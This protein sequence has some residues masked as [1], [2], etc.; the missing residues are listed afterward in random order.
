MSKE[1]IMFDINDVNINFLKVIANRYRTKLHDITPVHGRIIMS[2]YDSKND[3]C[4]KDI[5]EFV[6]CNKST[7]S[8]ILSTMEKNNLIVRLENEKDFRRKIIKLTD[9]ALEVIDILKKDKEELDELIGQNITEEEYI[10]FN[11]VLKKINE[12]LE[13]I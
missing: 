11:G 9:K 8:A 5:E 12:N 1:S 13:R 6:P 3:I 4:Q 10:I 2:I 7:L